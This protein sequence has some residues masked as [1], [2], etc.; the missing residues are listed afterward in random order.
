L[1]EERKQL[2]RLLVDVVEV[3]EPDFR[4]GVNSSVQ[5][6]HATADLRNW[7][8]PEQREQFKEIGG[9]GAFVHQGIPAQRDA[10]QVCEPV[11]DIGASQLQVFVQAN[12]WQAWKRADR[13][14]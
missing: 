2:R 4:L 11:E 6:R 10:P 8:R 13:V 14:D 12:F 5:G 7:P 1:A 3:S 9:H